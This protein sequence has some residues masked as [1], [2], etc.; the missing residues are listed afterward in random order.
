[1]ESLRRYPEHLPEKL[2]RVQFSGCQTL[3]SS[4]K[5]DA[6]KPDLMAHDRTTFFPL[7]NLD[8]S[9][10]RAIE[11]HC[12]WSCEKPSPFVALFAE[13]DQAFNFGLRF[14]WNQTTG[15]PNV[16]DWC[17]Y[18]IET[19]ALGPD[20]YI[21]DLD[22]LRQCLDLKLPHQSPPA[23]SNLSGTVFVL[24][25]VLGEAVVDCQTFH[26]LLEGMPDM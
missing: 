4:Y 10:H 18:T 25:R 17:V 3:F 22:H 23:A 13:K 26:E 11:A 6:T 8:R 12:K 9:F 5:H 24:E 19:F 2:Y 21:F 7:F 15:N 1:M 20:A 14:P 16:F